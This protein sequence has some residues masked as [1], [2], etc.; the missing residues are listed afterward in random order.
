MSEDPL[1]NPEEIWYTDESSFILDGK[2]I[3]RYVVV[4]SFET[5]EARSLPPGTS[6]QLAELI[7]LTRDLGKSV[8]IYTDSKYAFLVLHVHAAIW[9]ERGHLTTQGSPVKCGD[10]ILRVLETVHLPTEVSVSHCK[11]HH[12]GSTEVAR[13]NQAA[14]QAAKRAALQNNQV[15]MLPP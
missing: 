13:G 14:N 9:K 6:A 4:S 7:A 15:L 12:K 5:I 1:T 11:G 2:R 8:T 3:G 10:Q